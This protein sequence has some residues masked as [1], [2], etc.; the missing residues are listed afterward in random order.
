M[1]CKNLYSVQPSVDE[2]AE[3]CNGEY[4]SFS[5]VKAD[6]RNPYLLI[7][8][9]DTLNE[10]LTKI[11]DELERLSNEVIYLRNLL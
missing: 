8:E 1:E 10:V 5:C 3:E 11:T 6:Q 4:T 9:Q 7:R 2:S